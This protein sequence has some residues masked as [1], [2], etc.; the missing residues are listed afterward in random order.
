MKLYIRNKIISLRNG[1]IVTDDNNKEVLLVKGKF[2]TCTRKKFIC[3]LEGNKIYTVRNK[4]W[5]FIMPRAFIFDSNK[6]KIAKIKQKFS[7]KAQYTSDI[8]DLHIRIG[9]DKLFQRKDIYINEQ[10]VAT[11]SRNYM[12]VDSFEIDYEDASLAPLLTAIAICLDN[13]H[14][15]L[16]NTER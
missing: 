4:F 5:K 14:D 3:D 12:I 8:G 11:Y 2:F 1:S 9:S 7:V 15:D 13:M 10:K 16:S 6:K